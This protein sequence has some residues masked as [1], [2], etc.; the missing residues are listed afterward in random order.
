MSAAH[1]VPQAWPLLLTR[2]QLCAYLG[3]LSWGTLTKILPVAPLDLGANVL[4]Y[5]RPQVDAWAATLP[6]R[7]PKALRQE[8]ASVQGDQTTIAEAA[9]SD[10]ADEPETRAAVAVERARQRAM[11]LRGKGRSSWRKSDTSS[12]SSART[13]G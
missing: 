3:G 13:A 11:G 4:R 9:P 5:S 6:P 10:P 7:L 12:A 2:E 8:A 1:E